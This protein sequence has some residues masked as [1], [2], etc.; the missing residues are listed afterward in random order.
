MK[1]KCGQAAEAV[2]GLGPLVRA[3]AA[4]AVYANIFPALW[5]RVTMPEWWGLAGRL[6]QVM[7][8]TA[9]MVATA[10]YQG[11]GLV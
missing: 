6:A 1:S 3:A 11:Q 5:P 7:L 4:R 8:Q 9:V 10:H 2:V